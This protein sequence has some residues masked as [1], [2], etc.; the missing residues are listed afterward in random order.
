MEFQ[1]VPS[2]TKLYWNL[3][4]FHLKT[5]KLKRSETEYFGIVILF[6][7]IAIIRAQRCFSSVEA[8]SWAFV[9]AAM[10]SIRMARQLA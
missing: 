9:G 10:R 4:I 8:K 5:P 2:P 3:M 6:P 7:L 1:T